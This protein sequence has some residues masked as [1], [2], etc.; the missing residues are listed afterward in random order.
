MCSLREW[1]ELNTVPCQS[2]QNTLDKL[3][4]MKITCCWTFPGTV[5]LLLVKEE[6]SKCKKKKK[7]RYCR[8]I[9]GSCEA[10]GQC[11]CGGMV[12]A[13]WPGSSEWLHCSTTFRSQSAHWFQSCL[14][15]NTP[16]DPTILLPLEH[17]Q[18]LMIH[19][20]CLLSIPHS[21]VR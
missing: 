12:P 9:T 16:I 6:M 11:L 14:T 20:F 5:V 19:L 1:D 18:S 13:V 15:C 17:W 2:I 21:I 7:K 10:P 8:D 3:I 4:L